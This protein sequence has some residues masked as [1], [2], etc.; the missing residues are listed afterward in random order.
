MGA[1]A[2][3][4][5]IFKW[6]IIKCNDTLID[7]SMKK[8]N[9]CAVL[10]IAGFEMF[11]YNG[12]EQISI[13]FVNEKLQQFLKRS[14]TSLRPQI[15]HLRTRSRLNILAKVLQWPKLSPQL[16]LTLISLLSTTLEQSVTTSLGGWKRI[17]TLS[18][19][20]SL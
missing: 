11:D 13:N 3:F 16:T 4:D 9:F 18:M 12:F 2:T 1:R 7:K 15:S 20:L 8:A 5:R 14:L 17:K 10:D 19:T 6:L